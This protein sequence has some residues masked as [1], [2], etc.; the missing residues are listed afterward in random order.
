[1]SLII[2]EGNNRVRKTAQGGRKARVNED[3]YDAKGLEEVLLEYPYS[4]I[5]K[6]VLQENLW[7]MFKKGTVGIYEEKEQMFIAEGPKGELLSH[8]DP[9][10]VTFLE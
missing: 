5:P 7:L 2:P 8:I 9:D 4:S 1:M 6:S 10:F 3:I